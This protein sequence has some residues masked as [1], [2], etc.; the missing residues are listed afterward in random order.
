MR[1]RKATAHDIPD[2]VDL[3][4]EALQSDSYPELTI[5]R[6]RVFQR[7]S[8]CIASEKHFGYV[9][10][11]D[12]EVCGFL[13]AVVTPHAFYDGNAALVVGWY[14]RAGGGLRLMRRF[15]KWVD[16]NPRIT[17]AEYS[18]PRKNRERIAA[19]VRRLG[20]RTEVSTL[21]KLVQR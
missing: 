4:I 9:V 14:S 3:A 20:L 16:A 17:L 18:L 13:G 19:V 12:G 8:S 6:N 11:R 2:V 7:V 1:I 10:E 21:C 5:N 15:L